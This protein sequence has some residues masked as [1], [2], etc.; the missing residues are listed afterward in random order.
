MAGGIPTGGDR[1]KVLLVSSSSGSR[2]GGELFLLSLASGLKE[3]G[4]EPFL[5]CATHARMDELA[6]RFAAF[7]P[8]HRFS[9]RNS[10]DRLWRGMW[11]EAGEEERI[12]SHWRSLRPDVIHVNKQNPEDGLVL[13]GAADRMGLPSVCTVHIPRPPSELGARLGWWRDRTARRW[14]RK[15]QG[16]LV[17]VDP[18]CARQLEDFCGCP[19]RAVPNGVAVSDGIEPGQWRVKVRKEWGV[20]EG[21]PVFVAVGRLE[22]QKNPARFLEW[23]E[24]L[25]MALPQ[26]RFFWVGEGR[27]RGEWERR[28]SSMGCRDR[29]VLTGWQSDVRPFLSMADVFLHPASYEGL[30]LA[31]LEAAARGL[32]CVVD[33]SLKPT[34]G[35]LGEALWTFEEMP[36]GAGGQAVWREKGKELAGIIRTGYSLASMAAGYEALYREAAGF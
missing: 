13:L 20:E 12:A 14:L 3:R 33:R 32:P 21:E 24:S 22:E 1:V 18:C 28:V 23:V 7:G 34:L 26:A 10:Y 31:L 36:T 19:V 6:G 17:A 4:H 16:L 5:W 35:R 2:G 15:Y 25:S 27:W 9:Y 30:P 11:P 8:V 29:L